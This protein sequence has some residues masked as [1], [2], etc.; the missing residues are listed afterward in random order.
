LKSGVYTPD[1]AMPADL[2]IEEL[3]KRGVEIRKTT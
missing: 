3:A 1:Q 2:Y